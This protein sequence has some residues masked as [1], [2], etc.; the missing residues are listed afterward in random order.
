MTRSYGKFRQRCATAAV[1][2]VLVSTPV[3]IRAEDDPDPNQA[4]KNEQARI[5]TQVA[6]TKARGDLARTRIQALGLPSFD[7]TTTVDANG[8]AIE[9]TL[10]STHAVDAAAATIVEQLDN[11]LGRERKILLLAP[12]ENFDFGLVS[13]TIAQMD[14]AR[15]LLE[16]ALAPPSD[17]GA[18]PIIAAITAAAGL[19]RSD[20]TLTGLEV[21][22]ISDRLLTIAVASRLGG[23]AILP[24]ALSATIPACP[25]GQPAPPPGSAARPC[26]TVEF[27]GVDWRQMN[28]AQQFNFLAELRGSAAQARANIPADTEDEALKAQGAA[29][30]A[31]IARYDSLYSAITTADEHGQVPIAQAVRLQLLLAD[32]PAVVRVYLDRAGGSMLKQTNLLTWLGADPLRISGALVASYVI[33]DP[34]RGSVDRGGMLAC[35]TALTSVRSV[36]HWDWRPTRADRG[37]RSTCDLY[38]GRP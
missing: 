10:L 25:E 37:P 29:L 18:A 31:A 26:L 21:A 3:M 36:Q 33:T 9:A 16:R 35:R 5:E 30:D 6:I 20:S 4:L 24:T 22:G 1:V 8:G 12:T 7:G 2:L 19:L 23:R 28:I 38:A 27:R 11:Q 13:A 17:T 34:L 15:N 32:D 14:A